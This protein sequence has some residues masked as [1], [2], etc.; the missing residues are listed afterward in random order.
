MIMK[1]IAVIGGSGFIGSGLTRYLS[2]FC[3]VSCLG[4]GENLKV[5]ADQWGNPTYVQNLAQ[6]LV[7]L[8]RRDARG[9]FHMGGATFMTRYELVCDL[10]RSFDLDT[11]RVEPVSTAAAGLQ[12]VRPLRS[13]LCTGALEAA[14]ACQPMGFGE[15]LEQMRRQAAFRRDFAHLLPRYR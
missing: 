14:L 9:L 13:G 3:K 10:A 12:A 6:V 15:G 7:E 2:S 11:S 4:R 8:C 1:K 5:F